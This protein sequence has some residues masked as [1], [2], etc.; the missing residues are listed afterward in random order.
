MGTRDDVVLNDDDAV[1]SDSVVPVV[2]IVVVA[3]PR[4]RYR[5]CDMCWSLPALFM[6]NP[7]SLRV[8]TGR[9]PVLDLLLLDFLCFVRSLDEELNVEKYP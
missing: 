8:M 5:Y 7:W 9:S 2:T 1:S 4:G 6:N 3:V